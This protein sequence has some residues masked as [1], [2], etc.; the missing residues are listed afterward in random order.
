MSTPSQSANS[1]SPQENSKMAKRAALSAFLGSTVEYYDFVLFATASALIFNKV[2]FAS[3]G[4]TGSTLA[5]FATFGVAYVARPLGAI[6]FGSLGDRWGRVRTLTTTL[7]LM[8]LATTLIGC[9]PTYSTLGVAAPILLVFLRLL[10]GISAGGE[11][12]GSNSVSLE[13]APKEKRGLYTSWTMQ[14]TSFGSLIAAAIFIPITTLP[15]SSLLSWGWRIPFLL[16]APLVLVALYIRS[17]VKESE[18]FTKNKVEHREAKAPV[19]LVIRD[20]WPASCG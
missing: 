18:A 8:G 12:A 1:T 20:Y 13:H 17:S 10:Q 15:S 4:A 6:L 19:L 2:F 14:G 3:L 5:S 11:Q 7:V 9:L 16:A